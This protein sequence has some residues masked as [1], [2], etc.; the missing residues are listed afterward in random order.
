MRLRPA[1]P[2]DVDFFFDLRT[3]PAVVENSLSSSPTRGEHESWF[4]RALKDRSF[5]IYVV[6][7][8][9]AGEAIGMGRIALMQHSAELSLALVPGQRGKFKSLPLL[10]ILMEEAKLLGATEAT[11]RILSYNIPSLRAFFRAGFRPEEK[12]TRLVCDLSA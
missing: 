9:D 5:R 7:E 4:S 10:L 12:I 3:E 2:T 1:E 8:D 11:A 6:E